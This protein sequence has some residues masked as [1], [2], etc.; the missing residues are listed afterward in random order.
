MGFGGT[1]V[2]LLIE[3]IIKTFRTELYPEALTA[4]GVNVGYR[5]PNRFLIKVKYNNTN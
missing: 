3:E 5:F 4:G 1:D 2:L